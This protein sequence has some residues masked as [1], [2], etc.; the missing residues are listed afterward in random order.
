MDELWRLAKP[1]GIIGIQ[2][3]DSAAWR[4]V[5]EIRRLPLA[6]VIKFHTTR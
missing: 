6:Q 3:L 2:E 4:S 5:V 1:G